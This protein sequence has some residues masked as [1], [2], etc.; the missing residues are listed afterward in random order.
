MGR[1]CVTFPL[2]TE[3]YQEDILD[4]R[5]ELGRKMYNAVL[6]KAYKRYQCMVETKKYRGLKQQSKSAKEKERKPLNE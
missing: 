5:F 4:K 2:A 1:Y 6:S 3:I